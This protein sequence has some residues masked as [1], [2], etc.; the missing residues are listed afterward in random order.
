MGN[1]NRGDSRGGGNKGGYSG[2]GSRGGYGGG[3]NSYGGGGRGRNDRNDSREDKEMFSAV[4][5]ECGDNCEV[6]FKPTG[7]KPVLCRN[8]FRKEN[9]RGDSDFRGG[10]RRDNDR[11]GGDRNGGGRGGDRRD[12]EWRGPGHD[13]DRPGSDGGRKTMGEGRSQHYD[14]EFQKLNDKLDKIMQRLTPVH[15]RDGIKEPEPVDEDEES[16]LDL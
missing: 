5:A 14:H 15:T 8:C 11:R 9:D 13:S 7:N 12:N 1:Y 10:D 16:D 4:C 3:G 6:P 2:G